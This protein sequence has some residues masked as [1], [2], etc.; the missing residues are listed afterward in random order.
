MSKNIFIFSF[1]LTIVSQIYGEKIQNL[2]IT[3]DQ[4]KFKTG[5]SIEWGKED[6]TDD[7]WRTISCKNQWEF[8]GFGGY[9]GVAWYRKQIVFPAIFWTE[10]KSDSCVT[11]VYVTNDEDELYV[12]GQLIKKQP[13][14]ASVT[15]KSG[16]N[17]KYIIPL[18]VL[19][20][21]K[22]NVFAIRI[23][24]K[25]GN[26][27]LIT[28]DFKFH[29]TVAVDMLTV[30][31]DI[32]VTDWV[33][34]KKDKKQLSIKVSNP[35]NRIVEANLKLVVST[36]D[37]VK[38][39]SVI[40]YVKINKNS[41]ITSILPIKIKKPGFYRLSIQLEDQSISSLPVEFNVGYEPEKIK[42]PKD[43]QNDFS[44]FWKQSIED[45]KKVEP[46][47]KL[48]YMPEKSNGARDIYRV[49]MNSF[50]NVKIEGYYARPKKDGKYP[51]I[52][53]FM[54]YGADP[55]VPNSNS[56]VNYAQILLS[57][58]GQGIQ[59]STNKFGDWIVY[60]LDSK[61][62]YYYR[63]AYMDLIRAID[64]LCSRPE[65]DSNKIVA[66]G[67]SQGGAFTIVA[68][69]LDNRIKAAAP[70]IPFLSDFPDYFKIAAWPGNTFKTYIEKHPEYS[71][72]KIYTI[73]S[74]FDIKNFA[75]RIKCPVY[76]AVGLQDMVCPNHIN[77]AAYNQIKSKKSFKVYFNQEH[78]TPSEWTDLKMEF[79]EKILS[80]S[81]Q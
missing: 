30:N 25:T 58:R 81:N 24:N 44:E 3:D 74:Y 6:Y 23:K 1:F 38:L 34:Y 11:M 64:F 9:D 32:P 14:S 43:A 26:G 49:E 79:F 13:L 57:V 72:E 66:E 31:V 20:K 42:S 62:N 51:A 16:S 78:S 12:N 47:Y 29:P 28:E 53:S 35:L 36:D 33:Y 50:G 46:N 37:H 22:A 45:L 17:R 4:W 5:D 75:G 59:K 76:M 68:S 80:K 55:Y 63:G 52:A 69:A 61:E 27:G 41:D 19:K 73:L 2:K 40:T 67:G 10:I 70:S 15:G 7:K 60:G 48:T 54:G 8:Q 65:V 71:W 77:F 21:N 18:G 56:N 39:D